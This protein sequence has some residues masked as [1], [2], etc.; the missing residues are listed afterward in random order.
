MCISL[1]HVNVILIN[2]VC[3]P[4]TAAKYQQRLTFQINDVLAKSYCQ[5]LK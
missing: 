3:N 5:W 1:H 4:R 2:V